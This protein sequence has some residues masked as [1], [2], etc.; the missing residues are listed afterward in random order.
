METYSGLVNWGEEVGVS[1]TLL[2]LWCSILACSILGRCV[3]LSS[4]RITS[5]IYCNRGLIASNSGICRSSCVPF[6]SCCSSIRWGLILTGSSITSYVTFTACAIPTLCSCVRLISL[7]CSCIVGSRCAIGCRIWGSFILA[8]ISLTSSLV[9]YRIICAGR[10]V[11]GSVWG[12]RRC[13]GRC[14]GIFRVVRGCGGVCASR[15]VGGVVSGLGSVQPSRRVSGDIWALYCAVGG[16]ISGRS[17]WTASS[18]VCTCSS[19]VCT[20]RSSVCSVGDSVVRLSSLI[21]LL[22]CSIAAISCN[23]G[24]ISLIIS[25]VGLILHFCGIRRGRIG[26]GSVIGISCGI[27]AC[28]IRISTIIRRLISLVWWCWVILISSSVWSCVIGLLHCFI[29]FLRIVWAIAFLGCLIWFLWR[30]CSVSA[31]RGTV[32]RVLRG[33]TSSLIE[34]GA[35]TISI[36]WIGLA[37]WSVRGR[38]V[39]TH[40]HLPRRVIPMG[41]CPVGMCLR[42]VGCCIMSCGVGSFIGMCDIGVMT[43]SCIPS[44]CCVLRS[45][46]MR[47]HSRISSWCCVLRDCVIWSHS[48]ILSLSYIMRGSLIGTHGCISAR[49]YVMRDSLIG[50]HS[51]IPAW[52]YVFRGC[53]IGTNGCIT[54]WCCILR[55]SLIRCSG[56]KALTMISISHI[57]RCVIGHIRICSI[58]L[59]WRAIAWGMIRHLSWV[60][61]W[62]ISFVG[63]CRICG[64][65]V[66]GV[67]SLF[68][69]SISLIWGCGICLRCICLVRR[70]ITSSAVS[71]RIIMPIISSR[72][73]RTRIVVTIS[74]SIPSNHD[75]GR[76]RRSCISIS[77]W[78]GRGGTISSTGCLIGGSA[79][80]LSGGWITSDSCIGGRRGSIRVMSSLIGG[81][82]WCCLIAWLDGSVMSL[83]LFYFS[84]CLISYILIARGSVRNSYINSLIVRCVIRGMIGI[85]AVSS[86]VCVG[87]CC[88]TSSSIC[89]CCRVGTCA[90]ILTHI[91]GGW[92][93]GSWIRGGGG[94]GLSGVG[95]VRLLSSGVCGRSAVATCVVLSCSSTIPIT[96]S[97]ISGGVVTRTRLISICLSVV[98]AICRGSLISCCRCVRIVSAILIWGYRAVASCSTGTIVSLRCSVS[99]T[100]SDCRISASSGVIANSDIPRGRWVCGGRVVSSIS[101]VS[102]C[103]GEATEWGI[104]CEELLLSFRLTRCRWCCAVNLYLNI[105]CDSFW[106][107]WF[108][109]IIEPRHHN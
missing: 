48:R 43:H 29:R 99:A 105:G 103:G 25:I 58:Y 28:L 31:L 50:A 62:N 102:A 22:D 16:V 85:R 60:A 107:E 1:W 30:I 100:T 76:I 69:G 4:I 35:G 5:S 106:V 79:V 36:R 78:V 51:C 45:C 17:I 101:G 64:P 39:V 52:C 87:I 92:V 72:I 66:C 83:I 33:I 88:V 42:C 57:G 2:L 61:A 77:W 54:A 3:A 6:S 74:C 89:S 12:R 46:V 86:A 56:V 84:T 44:W 9:C 23:I 18:S 98:F 14:G 53:L 65:G 90:I 13:V 40:N 91:W 59:D 32:I 37:C 75:I 96:T 10:V 73:R 95:A 80:I 24:R 97:S 41:S 70:R 38:L 34:V 19:S 109:G 26:L 27:Q 67:V 47:S 108:L 11:C 63:S 93:V 21:L 7:I 49:A 15:R 82:V 94:V 68:S 20:A 8:I 104:G 71:S 55:G 81:G